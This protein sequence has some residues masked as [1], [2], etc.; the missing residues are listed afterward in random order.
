VNEIVLIAER[1]RNDFILTRMILAQLLA[2]LTHDDPCGITFYFPVPKQ[3]GDLKTTNYQLQ[4]RMCQLVIA[5][6]IK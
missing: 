2:N 3:N 4:E 5:L 6:A 1:T